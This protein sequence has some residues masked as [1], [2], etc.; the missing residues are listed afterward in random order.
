MKR[1][2]RNPD[3]LIPYMQKDYRA[4]QYNIYRILRYTVYI[5]IVR[6][7]LGLRVRAPEVYVCMLCVCDPRNID[8]VFFIIHIKML[9]ACY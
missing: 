4:H 9:F 6:V 2:S 8:A 1:A 5:H 7:R 3:T